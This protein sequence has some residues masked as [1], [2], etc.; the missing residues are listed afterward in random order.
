[1][2]LR[3][4][5]DVL[6]LSSG[7]VGRHSFVVVIEGIRLRAKSP[8][9]TLFAVAAGIHHHILTVVRSHSGLGIDLA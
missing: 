1:M 9:R 8:T 5:R 7:V 6:I 2:S 3:A 4:G